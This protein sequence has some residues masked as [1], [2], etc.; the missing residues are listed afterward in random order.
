MKTHIST[1]DKTDIVYKKAVIMKAWK[2]HVVKNLHATSMY[3]WRRER[4]NELMSFGDLELANLYNKTVLHKAKQL[5]IDKK[6]SLGKVSDPIASILQ[7]KYKPEFAAII[8]KIGLNFMSFILVPNLQLFLYKQFVRQTEKIGILS[9][10][11]TGSLIKS[12]KKPDD[13]TD[14]TFLYQAVVPY[15]TKILPVLQMIL[16]KHK[17][18]KCID[19]LVMR[20]AANWC[21]LSQR[22]H[23]WLFFCILKCRKLSHSTDAISTYISKIM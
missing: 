3:G 16:T 12:I 20:I 21:I 1:Y 17:W 5:G 14:F 4:A 10:N 18:H 15:K 19:I 9:I 8:R 6:L 2:S 11:V 22:G 7:L 23:N 13:F